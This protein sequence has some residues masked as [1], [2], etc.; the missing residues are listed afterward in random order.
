M[1]SSMRK[2]D[3]FMD[4]LVLPQLTGPSGPLNNKGCPTVLHVGIYRQD[5]R[6]SALFTDLLGGMWHVTVNC[7]SDLK[8]WAFRKGT[9]IH[10]VVKNARSR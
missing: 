9:Q 4:G 7:C 1:V 6:S 2:K 5:H 3:Y 10:R 8:R